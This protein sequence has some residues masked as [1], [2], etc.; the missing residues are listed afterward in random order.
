MLMVGIC[1]ALPAQA[2]SRSGDRRAAVIVGADDGGDGTHP[3]R[4]AITD[5]E[6]IH[7]ILTTIGGVA[8]QDA[9]LL[10]QPTAEEVL[11]ALDEA[12]RKAAGGTLVFYY[13]GHALQG[14]LHLGQ[15]T[16]PLAALKEKLGAL[17]A[18]TKIAILDSCRS[19]ELI[20]SKG[21]RIAP[22]FEVTG[23]PSG[24]SGLAIV[25]SS[26]SNEDSQESDLLGASFFTHFF[27]SG[28][29]G[30]ADT[31]G[32][33]KVSLQEAYDYAYGRTVAETAEAGAVQHPTYA[34][35]LSGAGAVWLTDVARARSTLVLGAGTTGAYVIVDA[36]RRTLVA[37][38]DKSSGSARKIALTAGLYEVKRR[39]G[40]GAL[41]AKVKLSDGDTLTL[42]DV[43]MSHVALARALTKGDDWAGDLAT[44]RPSRWIVS[45][46][47]AEQF[48]FAPA[49]RTGLFPDLPLGGI[50]VQVR[51][52]FNSQRSILGLDFAVGG[53][54]LSVPVAAQSIPTQVM[55]YTGGLSYMYE[56]ATGW[57]QPYVG[58]RLSLV[59][60]T[61]SFNDAQ[62]Q[63]PGQSLVTMAPGITAG[64]NF[65]VTRHLSLG[66][67][68][69]A[70]YLLYEAD[71]NYSLGYADVGVLVRWEL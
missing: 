32:D 6:R 64:V 63:I 62:M 65:E 24:P 57:I 42:N 31:S 4:Y 35:K 20:R 54:P 36:A 21:G 30:D 48:F 7:R 66:L 33:G 56:L 16:L 46:M 53:A 37:E 47:G 10:K 51:D 17:Q 11:A 69:R 61:R 58:A 8:P 29:L 40:S 43:G 38:V 34:W 1:C 25:A 71:D 39:D 45:A 49:T 27:A 12:D 28:L 14:L 70:N 68:A 44:V 9:R 5:A 3:L 23:E 59:G 60:V 19:G 22:A 41:F 13:S 55:E 50:D 2:D 67:R 52:L 18:Q 15:T 26:A